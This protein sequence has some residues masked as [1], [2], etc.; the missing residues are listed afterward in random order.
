MVR[1]ILVELDQ[2]AEENP[3]HGSLPFLRAFIHGAATSQ[4]ISI[5]TSTLANHDPHPAI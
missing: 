3:T 5:R 1:E 2:L 4:G